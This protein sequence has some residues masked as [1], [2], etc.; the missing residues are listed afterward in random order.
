MLKFQV[1]GCS[2]G[3]AHKKLA[4]S[5]YLLIQNSRRILFD[6]GE[7]A[8]SAM[9][10]L[11]IDP[12]TIETIF[13]SH[14]HPDHC[15]GLPLFIQANY[16]LKRKQRLDIFVPSEAVRGV[17]ALFDMTYLYPLKLP[18]EIEVHPFDPRSRFEMRDL[19]IEAHQNSH[20]SRHAASIRKL[21]MKNRI[22][23]FTFVI[24][25]SNKKIVYSGD[26]G[27]EED[28]TETI[29]TADL[30]IIE[31]SHIDL[32]RLGNMLRAGA[33]KRVIITHLGDRINSAEIRR[34]IGRAPAVSI[35][36][37]REGLSITL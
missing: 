29:E 26:L 28:I 32:S 4:C 25:A 5:S 14:M 15:M 30:L 20:L 17:K 13:I 9:R 6:C 1:I 12:R 31:R 36:I 24:Q 27:S 35:Q 33:V 7:G 34:R 16:V 10:R 2:S 23:C 22:Q 8:T 11:G 21:G 3:F 19:T 18:F 37:A